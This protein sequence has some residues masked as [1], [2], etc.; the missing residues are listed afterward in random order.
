MLR[1]CK[2]HSAK[3][4]LAHAGDVCWAHHW[5]SIGR[6]SRRTRANQ[7]TRHMPSVG[8]AL[9]NDEPATRNV[10]LLKRKLRRHRDFYRFVKASTFFCMLFN[11][12]L[13]A[14]RCL[15]NCHLFQVSVGSNKHDT[16]SCL[17]N[18]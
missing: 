5:Y 15:I 7:I 11:M 8:F 10:C 13:Y 18:Y 12:I 9:G 14:I 16:L 4:N 3:R 17:F 1:T 2:I 6:N